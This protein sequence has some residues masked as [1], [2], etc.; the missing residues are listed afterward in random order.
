[1]TKIKKQ[2]S[3]DD[4][5]NLEWEFDDL[6]LFGQEFEP[7][8]MPANLGAAISLRSVCGGH[9]VTLNFRSQQ[10]P[11]WGYDDKFSTLRFN[12][13]VFEDFG[14]DD[15]DDDEDGTAFEYLVDAHF[16]KMQFEIFDYLRDILNGR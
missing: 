8:E 15:V 5:K 2:L 16:K 1:M 6:M 9:V 12:E 10:E 11:Q 4:V 14:G 7:G 13:L 3:V